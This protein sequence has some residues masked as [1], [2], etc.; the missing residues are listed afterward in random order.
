MGN[1]ID[2]FEERHEPR[3][4]PC[5]GQRIRKLNPHRMCKSKVLLLDYIARQGGFVKISTGNRLQLQGDAAVHALRLQWFGLVE[6]GPN[7]SGL[8][9]AT[10]DGINFL[11][12]IH[13]VPKV[14]W[15]RGGK[16]IET[17]S[18]KVSIG[19]IKNVVFDKKYWDN[20]P[21]EF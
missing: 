16:V 20:Y 12:G 18:V 8:Y 9:R 13:M 21:R 17:D 4:C 19:S 11:R 2:M 1:Q 6:H 3:T 14:I 5:C 15:C 7:R 10:D